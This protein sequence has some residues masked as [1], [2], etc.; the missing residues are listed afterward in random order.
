MSITRSLALASVALCAVASAAVASDLPTMKGPP[1]APTPAPYSWT[2]FDIG[3]QAGYGWGVENDDLST[4]DFIEVPIDHFSANGAFGG[5]HVGYDQQI[6]SLVLGVRGEFDA[7][8]LNGSTFGTSTTNVISACEGCSV[9]DASLAF[10]NTWQ[11]FL[12]GRAGFA[13]DRV[14]VYATGGL[15]IGDD[16]EN[17]TATQTFEG[18]IGALLR[19]PGQDRR[20]RR[21]SAAR[22]AWARNTRSTI[23]GASA[24]NGATSIS[25]RGI[26]RRPAPSI[27]SHTRRASPRT[28]RSLVLSYGF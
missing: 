7:T 12:L 27:P 26:I 14:L 13:F 8:G 16:R 4:T 19:R 22:S 20:P 11:A 15:A 24:R 18:G 28:S 2:G 3:L 17:V 6:G 5:A 10:R 1:P 21:S 23:T 25:P 9:T